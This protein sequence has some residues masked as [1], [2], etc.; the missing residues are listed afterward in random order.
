MYCAVGS[1]R[2]PVRV[3]GGRGRAVGAVLSKS[4]VVF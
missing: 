1:L 2:V 3:P 4:Q